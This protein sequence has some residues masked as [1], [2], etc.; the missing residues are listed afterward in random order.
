MESKSIWNDTFTVEYSYWKYH[1]N[2]PNPVENRETYTETFEG[3]LK[4]LHRKVLSERRHGRASINFYNSNGE[5]LKNI[6]Y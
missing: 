3:S 4:A 2:I 6:M 1:E 5:W